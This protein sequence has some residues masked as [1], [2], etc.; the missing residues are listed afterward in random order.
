[1]RKGLLIGWALLSLVWAGAV[2][3]RAQ[4]TW[5]RLS[6]DLSAS[7]AQTRAL[8]DRAV[9]R[10]VAWHAAGAMVPPLLLLAAGWPM[11]RRKR[12]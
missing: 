1:M 9:S 7:D 4:A 6:M 8:Y 5:P 10:H 12:G 2:A 11:L 3:I